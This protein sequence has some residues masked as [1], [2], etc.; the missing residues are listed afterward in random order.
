VGTVR[1]SPLKSVASSPLIAC[2]RAARDGGF[3]WRRPLLGE[4][5]CGFLLLSCRNFIFFLFRRPSLL[6]P[7]RVESF[8]LRIKALSTQSRRVERLGFG[9]ITGTVFLVH[10]WKECLRVVAGRIEAGLLRGTGVLLF[11][12]SC[13][14]SRLRWLLM[15]FFGSSSRDLGILDYG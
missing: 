3:C 10:P 12:G 8:F 4:V 15:I 7:R 11:R 6:L 13:R 14:R 2:S 9:K 1:A 5:S